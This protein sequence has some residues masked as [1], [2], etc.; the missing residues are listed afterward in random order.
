MTPRRKVVVSERGNYCQSQSAGTKRV[1]R[2]DRVTL[3]I[4]WLYGAASALYGRGLRQAPVSGM[5]VRSAS[6]RS[7]RG[8]KERGPG[9]LVESPNP[10]ALIRNGLQEPG[11]NLESFRAG[12]SHVGP[13]PSDEP[14]LTGVHETLA[15]QENGERGPQ[16]DVQLRPVG[17]QS[18]RRRGRGALR[19]MP[20]PGREGHRQPKI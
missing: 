10:L 1:S 12:D 7:V 16:P 14:D 11:H 5:H 18:G 6:I 13:R 17:N 8:Q 15:Q 9:F 2:Y 19:V 20:C 4:S 3:G